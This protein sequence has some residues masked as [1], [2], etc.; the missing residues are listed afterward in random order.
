MASVRDLI[1]LFNSICYA[2]TL[3]KGTEVDVFFIASVNSVKSSEKAFKLFGK[4]HKVRLHALWLCK[5]N[6]FV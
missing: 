5:D 3:V 4:A 1:P 2:H 6:I